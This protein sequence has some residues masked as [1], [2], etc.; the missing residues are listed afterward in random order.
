MLF[1]FCT[2]LD[3]SQK[4]L[5]IKRSLKAAHSTLLRPVK[6]NLG[7]ASNQEAISLTNLKHVGQNLCVIQLTYY[8]LKRCRKS[9]SDYF[10]ITWQVETPWNRFVFYVGRASLNWKICR[11]VFISFNGK[12]I[13]L[14]NNTLTIT[15]ARFVSR[16]IS[17]SISFWS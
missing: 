10:S 7:T 4:L 8:H 16:F 17:S 1:Y 14:T 12:Y 2:T 11:D 15:W 5:L 6:S 13:Y 3:D 9:H